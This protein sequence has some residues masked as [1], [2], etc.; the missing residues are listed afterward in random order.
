MVDCWGAGQQV[1]FILTNPVDCCFLKGLY[2][3][4]ASRIIEG[5]CGPLLIHADKAKTKEKEAQEH[6]RQRNGDTTERNTAA[7]WRQ[8]LENLPDIL[9]ETTG[10][11]SMTQEVFLCTQNILYRAYHQTTNLSF[12]FWMAMVAAGTWMLSNF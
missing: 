9:V 4:Q 3:D 1:L 2:R 6:V 10:S 11:G 8:E 7:C 5:A 12:F